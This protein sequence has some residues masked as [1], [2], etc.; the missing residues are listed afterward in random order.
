[1]ATSTLRKGAHIFCDDLGGGA[2]IIHG[3]SW[4]QSPRGINHIFRAKIRGVHPLCPHR[5]MRIRIHSGKGHAEL[6]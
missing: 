4:F 3:L 2:I 5:G 6:R 1:M